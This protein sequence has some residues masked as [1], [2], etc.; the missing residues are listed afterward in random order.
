MFALQKVGV[1]TDFFK[2]FLIAT[3]SI[4][5]VYY[6]ANVQAE[7]KKEAYF[8]K[9]IKFIVLFPIF[10]ALSMGLS[11]HNS[12]A[13]I[14]GY[15]GK[16]SPFIRTPKFNIQDLRDS[17]KNQNYLAKKLPLTTIFEGL[18]AIY[19]LCA[20]ISGFYL[21]SNPFFIFHLMLMLGYGTI[22]F[23]SVRHLSYK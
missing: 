2:Y 17:F 21:S 5:I 7:L 9:L 18:L 8:K 19:F 12:I 20:I 16:Q 22:C 3:V 4:I 10:L 11:L 13:V 6:V 23:Y 15:I 1:D 14:Q